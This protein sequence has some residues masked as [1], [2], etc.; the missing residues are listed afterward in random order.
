MWLKQRSGST[1]HEWGQWLAEARA[2][3]WG[4]S[5]K[6]PR[7]S[8]R[9]PIP[10]LKFTV[11]S[12][13]DASDK[14]RSIKLKD[15]QSS[16]RFGIKFVR[17]SITQRG[18]TIGH[19]KDYPDA[20]D[21]LQAGYECWILPHLSQR[22]VIHDEEAVRDRLL[23]AC[24]G[25]YRLEGPA[26]DGSKCFEVLDGGLQK[27]MRFF[28]LKE[29]DLSLAFLTGRA[30]TYTGTHAAS[31]C[32]RPFAER[33]MLHLRKSLVFSTESD[34]GSGFECLLRH[35]GILQEDRLVLKILNMRNT[36]A[37]SPLAVIHGGKGAA[38][39][40]EVPE[41]TR[42]ILCPGDRLIFV[43]P[44]PE[45]E[46]KFQKCVDRLNDEHFLSTLPATERLLFDAG[47]G[48]VCTRGQGPHLYTR[49][50]LCFQ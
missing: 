34:W 33:L 7:L 13:W 45:E 14:G 26:A 18:R 4:T 11:P 25:I 48:L 9:V 37:I 46:K 2:N 29:D 31:I 50:R 10:T 41:T 20:N 27:F 17:I 44:H 28:Q 40:W 30:V 36:F 38:G 47:N 35:Q 21:E 39:L 43:E 23:E 49:T 3:M 19:W 24:A 12:K 6:E 42:T 16:T 8:P 32:T 5:K 22:V 15:L 1:L